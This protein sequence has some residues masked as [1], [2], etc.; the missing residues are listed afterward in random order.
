MDMQSDETA[1]TLAVAHDH[2]RELQ[3]DEIESALKNLCVLVGR[4]SVELL[5]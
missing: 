2:F 3:R 4:D 1:N 5:L